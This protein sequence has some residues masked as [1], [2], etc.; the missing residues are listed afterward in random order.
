MN[1]K[2]TR[3]VREGVKVISGSHITL[4]V[5]GRFLEFR[6]CHNFANLFPKLSESTFY[7]EI[8]KFQ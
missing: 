5:K 2:K 8:S 6:M 4:C 7:E 1:E 3:E